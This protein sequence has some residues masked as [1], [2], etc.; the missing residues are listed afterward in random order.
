ME[1]LALIGDG[2]PENAANAVH[3]LADSE[4]K[5]YLAQYALGVAL[6]QQEQYR[7]AIEYLHKAVE[8]QPD[9]AWAHYEMG[10]CLVK[11][12]DYKSAVVHLEIATKRLPGFADAQLLLT[13][14]QRHESEGKQKS[15]TSSA[16]P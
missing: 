11:T 8:L 5:M 6:A 3:A 9:S 4:S 15:S 10:S 16:K 1:A 12:G 7:K 14:A 2:K 13:Q